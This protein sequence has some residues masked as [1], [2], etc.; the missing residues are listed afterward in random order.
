MSR[1]ALE[2]TFPPWRSISPGPPGR[3]CFLQKSD[4]KLDV[5]GADVTSCGC[6]FTADL[7]FL[8]TKTNVRHRAFVPRQAGFSLYE[9]FGPFF[10]ETFKLFQII[11]HPANF[12]LFVTFHRQYHRC[13]DGKQRQ[14]CVRGYLCQVKGTRRSPT[15]GPETGRTASEGRW[16]PAHR[17]RGTECS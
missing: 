10:W 15:A 17:T 1:L 16:P 2:Q 4:Y 12:H 13:T 6:W 3:K 11:T 7:G 8:R 9:V 14:H 5:S